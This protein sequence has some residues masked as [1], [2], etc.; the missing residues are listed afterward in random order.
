MSAMRDDFTFQEFTEM[1]SCALVTKVPGSPDENDIQPTDR[2]RQ[3]ET[4]RGEVL[5][6]LLCDA[7]GRDMES[8]KLDKLVPGWMDMTLIELHTALKAL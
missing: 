7:L 4:L 5:V 8:F 2:L 3:W 1:I 6:G